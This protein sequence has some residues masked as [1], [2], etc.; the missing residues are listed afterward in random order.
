MSSRILVIEDDP[1]NLDLFRTL[2]QSDGYEVI[3]SKRAYEEI[4]EVE[5][6][7]SDLIILDIR[8]RTRREGFT[9][10][11]K[12]KLFR[13]TKDIPVIVCTAAVEFIQEHEAALQEKGIP[14]ICKPF[15]IDDL[16]EA[17]HQIL[18]SPSAA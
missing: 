5:A 2:L 14:I 1:Y 6:I 10:L 3:L 9:F 12:L 13:P 4:A 18:S 17:V 11:Q 8:L 16:L 7:H 15:N